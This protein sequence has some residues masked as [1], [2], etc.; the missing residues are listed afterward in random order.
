MSGRD[1]WLTIY[2]EKTVIATGGKGSCE[3]ANLD[4][5]DSGAAF[6]PNAKRLR[7]TSGQYQTL[8]DIVIGGYGSIWPSFV[9]PVR[10]DR[11]ALLVF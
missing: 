3:R 5:K 8:N 11:N 1:D 6:A 10:R 2:L 9:E 4:D 7:L